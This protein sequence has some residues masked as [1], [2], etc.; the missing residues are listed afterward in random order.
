MRTKPTSRSSGITTKFIV[1]HRAYHGATIMAGHGSTIVV[2]AGGDL[3]S[4]L[5]LQGGNFGC[6]PFFLSQVT[7]ETKVPQI[8]FCRPFF[9][10]GVTLSPY[11]CWQFLILSLHSQHWGPSC[12]C[13]VFV[14]GFLAC[15]RI[16][17]GSL[18]QLLP[19]I[20]SSRS[21]RDFLR[22]RSSDPRRRFRCGM[23]NRAWQSRQ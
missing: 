3:T 17:G 7:H 10:I 18:A 14:G 13:A 9:V 4:T 11:L 6:V 1:L 19:E 2:D 20:G 21:R 22:N 8:A 5:E 15:G 23:A 16:Q 12:P